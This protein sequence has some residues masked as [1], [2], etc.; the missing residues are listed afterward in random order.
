LGIVTRG[1]E[2]EGLAAGIVAGG[3]GQVALAMRTLTATGQ[4]EEEVRPAHLP[5]RLQQER[6]VLVAA[7]KHGGE[8]TVADVALDTALSL[9]EA[10]ELLL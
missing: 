1:E 6:E 3:V 8:V 2:W 5:A 4:S 7:R 9:D 10:L